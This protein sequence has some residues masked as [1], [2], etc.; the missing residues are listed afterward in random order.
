MEKYAF[1]SEER[2]YFRIITYKNDK[3]TEKMVTEEC[4]QEL[5]FITG[6]SLEQ[7]NIDLYEMLD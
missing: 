7:V 2:N 1:I 3:K 4:L 6:F 5:E